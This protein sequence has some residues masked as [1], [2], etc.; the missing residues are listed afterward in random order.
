MKAD[1]GVMRNE[2]G[3]AQH[4]STQEMRVVPAWKAKVVSKSCT[5]KLIQVLSWVVIET[6]ELL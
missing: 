3:D 2:N 6:K 1:Q 4:R 5:E